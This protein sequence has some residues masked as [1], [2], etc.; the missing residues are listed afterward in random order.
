M[1]D[2]IEETP[3]QCILAISCF[4]LSVRLFSTV[5]LSA[6]LVNSPPLCGASINL[7]LPLGRV[8]LFSLWVNGRFHGVSMEE[9]S[10][11]SMLSSE[12]SKCSARFAA[13]VVEERQ[14]KLHRVALWK[15]SE[16][17]RG[18]RGRVTRAAQMQPTSR[19][20]SWLPENR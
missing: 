4:L 10:M 2:K 11:H 1:A 17:Q 9:L 14:L 20:F 7:G 8:C 6:S 19:A 16:K 18:E 12:L 15:A 13:I 3:T 5:C